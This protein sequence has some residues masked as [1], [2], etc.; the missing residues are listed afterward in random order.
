MNY[1]PR[2]PR[3]PSPKPYVPRSHPRPPTTG[4]RD[5]NECGAPAY[6][7]HA[8]DCPRTS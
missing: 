6:S 8:P 4:T 5:C 3:L 7:H 2:V 1:P